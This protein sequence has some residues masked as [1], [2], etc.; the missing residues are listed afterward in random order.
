ML[1][2]LSNEQ[3]KKKEEEEGVQQSICGQFP[4]KLQRSNFPSILSSFVG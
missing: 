1:G 3:K 2:S 4:S